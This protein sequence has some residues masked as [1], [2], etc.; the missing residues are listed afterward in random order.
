MSDL[1]N[2]RKS[3]L[4]AITVALTFLFAVVFIPSTVESP[5]A[6][7]FL[8]K[9]PG[10]SGS[11]VV[12]APNTVLTAKH[13]ML[14]NSETDMELDVNGLSHK[15]TNINSMP[16]I[17]VSI[18]TTEI[19]C[20]CRN[21]IITQPRIGEPVWAVGYPL[22]SLIHTEVVSMGEF[23]G[24]ATLEGNRIGITT[25]QVDPGISGGA[26]FVKRNGKFYLVGIVV[27]LIGSN[28]SG[29]VPVG[30]LPKSNYFINGD[31]QKR[32]IFKIIQQVF[33]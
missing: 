11:A 17:D 3:Y 30:E 2:N 16:V 32:L 20:P 10:G 29:Y 24:Y 15:I 33:E 31:Q 26:M 27:Y 7:V 22:G 8:L 14:S 25:A 28:L 12:I 4:L 23:Q 19:A 18:L 13:V 1:L 21:H 6:G 5:R 9:G